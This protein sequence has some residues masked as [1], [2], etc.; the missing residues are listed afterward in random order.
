MFKKDPVSYKQPQEYYC[1][2]MYCL[3]EVAAHSLLRDMLTEEALEKL[4]E[5]YCIDCIV[6]GKTDV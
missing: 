5:Y 6:E 2:N 1:S 3:N 4:A